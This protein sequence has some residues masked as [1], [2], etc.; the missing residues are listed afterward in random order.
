MFFVGPP[1][2]FMV[3]LPEVCCG[4]SAPCMACASVLVLCAV[5]KDRRPGPV[6]V[7]GFLLAPVSP[8][9]PEFAPSLVPG[10]PSPGFSPGGF[11]YLHP[12]WSAPPPPPPLLCW[13]GGWVPWV[14][15]RARGLL[16][17]GSSSAPPLHCSGE[18]RPTRRWRRLVGLMERSP[19]LPGP[20]LLS[21]QRNNSLCRA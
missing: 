8:R 14:G 7:P 17:R 12:P 9:A 20:H 5:Q 3:P 16:P 19:G 10:S 11:S 6:A 21:C 2:P 4:R 1:D 15:L 18:Y 13:M